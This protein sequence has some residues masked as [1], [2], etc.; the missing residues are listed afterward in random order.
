NLL[1][2]IDSLL[3][4]AKVA[5]NKLELDRGEFSLRAELSDVLCALAV[6]AHRKGL[7]LVGD[8]ADDV[9]DLMIGDA[10]RLRQV[11]IN[12][13]GNAI[14]FTDAGEVVVTVETEA[15]QGDEVAVRFMVRDTGI[16]IPREKHSIIFE[17]FAQEDASTTKRYGGTGVGLTIASRLAA[18]MRG[19]V[20]G[21]G[22]PGHGSAFTLTAP[23]GRGGAAEGPGV[24]ARPAL[25]R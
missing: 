10:G 22:G 18:P 23:F 5:A 12:L 13:V 14:K 15:Q 9:P 16:G 7:E 17:A 20:P 1:G 6:R 4:F 21:V 3:D 25:A 2:I 8:V 19:P 11:L 24:G